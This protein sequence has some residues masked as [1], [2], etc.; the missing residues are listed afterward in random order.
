MALVSGLGTNHVEVVH[1]LEV[2]PEVGRHPQGLPDSQCGVRRNGP[3]A[4]NDI[5]DKYLRHPYRLGQWMI[6]NSS[7]ISAQMLSR[8]NRFGGGQK[9]P[10]QC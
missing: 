4:A 6:P 3:A 2:Q 10:P 7:M 1:P 5:V 8:V 9:L